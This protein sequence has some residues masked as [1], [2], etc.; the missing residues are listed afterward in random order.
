MRQQPQRGNADGERLLG[1][2]TVSTE[3]CEVERLEAAVKRMKASLGLLRIR[4]R[5]NRSSR[6]EEEP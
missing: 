6:D 3:P 5:N 4:E 1:I 2:G